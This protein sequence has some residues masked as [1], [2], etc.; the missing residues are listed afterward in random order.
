MRK[1]GWLSRLRGG[2]RSQVAGPSA[3]WVE[4]EV[5]LGEYEVEGLLGE[6]GMGVVYRVRSRATGQQFAVKRARLG[7]VAARR[8]F[9]AELQTWIDLPEYPHLVAC[10]FF[11]TVGDEIAIFAEYV[12]GGSLGD[13]IRDRRLVAL[14]AVLDV[15]VQ[16][17]W[18]LGALHEWGLVHGDVKPGNVLLTGEGVAKVADFGLARARAVVGGMTPAYCS[19]EQAAGRPLTVATDV[20]SWGVSV[21][22]MFVGGVT[23]LAGQAAGEALAGYVERGVEDR[24]LPAMPAGVV[25]L[26]ERCFEGDPARRPRMM[27]VAEALQDVYGTVAGQ[28]YPRQR[29]AVPNPMAVTRRRSVV[30]GGAWRD[31]RQWLQ[32]ALSQAG[33]DPTQVEARAPAQAGSP[34]AQA[35]ADLAL[36]EEAR[37]LLEGLIAEG[38]RDLE[39][40]LASLCEEEA[41]VHVSVDDHRGALALFDR[42]IAL[43]QGRP[44]LAAALAGTCVS[45][46][47]AL[48]ALGTHASAAAL[49]DQAIALYERLLRGRAGPE[50][51]RD[52]AT[53]CM[54]KGNALLEMGDQRAAISAYDRAIAACE[55]LGA[56]GDQQQ[57]ADLVGIIYMNKATALRRLGDFP[58]A[59][60]LHGQAV[61]IYERLVQQEGR[62]EFAPDLAGACLNQA[63][64]AADL[65]EAQAAATL[66]RRAVQLYQG[67]VDQGHEELAADLA[68]A[69]ENAA[70]GLAGLGDSVAAIALF[71]RAIAIY[72]RLVKWEGRTELANNLAEAYASRANALARAGKL[73]EALTG[74]D[75]A[76]ALWERLARQPGQWPLAI[77]LGRACLNKAVVATASGDRDSALDLYSQAQATYDGLVRQGRSELRGDAARVQAQRAVLLLKL[78]RVGEAEALGRAAVAS[79]REEAARTGRADLRQALIE[80][81]QDLKEVL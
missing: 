12:G 60:S 24:G 67:L 15:A 6:G 47:I 38:R 39:A 68:K 58:A 56:Q 55:R 37:Q 27:E 30:G 1:D 69:C 53:A 74:Y 4:G 2:Q 10:R 14:P 21:L 76:I 50:Q 43:R 41:L 13:W 25:G 63:A 7:D 73:P 11:R 57:L 59:F 33:Q 61:A 71:D 78:G 23:W 20:W 5:V 45:K 72:D 29:P 26:L 75:Q 32:E 65:G 52:L 44:H 66:S 19:P 36:F 31:P 81:E 80:A 48:R 22:E 3:R 46:A 16:M 42:A 54:E 35:V 77:Y 18:G 40:R 51:V 8:R 17:A 34:R 49:C 28:A 64:T 9:L 62:Q 70:L 79:L